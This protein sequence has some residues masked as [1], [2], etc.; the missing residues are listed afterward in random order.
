MIVTLTGPSC[1]GKS[2]L[3]KMLVTRGF[4][5]AISTT[6][7][8][9]RAGEVDGEN[10]YFATREGFEQG[11]QLGNFVE[12]VEFGGNY[13]GLSVMEVLR[14]KEEGKPIVVVCEPVGQKQIVAWCKANQFPVL[15]VWVGNPLKVVAERFMRR[16]ATE[17]DYG[18]SEKLV[19]SYGKRLNEMM[20]TERDWAHEAW[21]G[22]S[23]IQ[24]PYN[25]RL[26]EFNEQNQDEVVDVIAG[27]ALKEPEP[28]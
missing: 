11:V 4:S 20:T 6:T 3:E 19:V 21:K 10:Y 9:P 24:S 26:A 14:L 23:S 28:A 15:G 12:H 27:I 16:F 25:L 2:T 18:Y 1:A 13:Y 7:R 22:I 5:N 17:L 8:Q